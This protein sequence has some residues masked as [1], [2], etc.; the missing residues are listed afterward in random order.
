MSKK[1]PECDNNLTEINYLECPDGS[2]SKLYPKDIY[3]KVKGKQYH[4]YRFFCNKCNKEWLYFTR[5]DLRYFEEIEEPNFPYDSKKGVLTY[6][7][8]KK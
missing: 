3:G 8:V 2:K 6:R 7:E 1:C 5:P 4:E